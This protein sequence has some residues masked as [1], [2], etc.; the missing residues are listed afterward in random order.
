LL[1]A[2]SLEQLEAYEDAANAYEI[3]LSQAPKNIKAQK[4]SSIYT[5]PN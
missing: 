4:H 2:Q 5:K 3:T 1:L